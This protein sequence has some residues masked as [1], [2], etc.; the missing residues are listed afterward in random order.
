MAKLQAPSQG[1]VTKG[2]QASVPP[3]PRRKPRVG[4]F[5]F[6]AQ[7]RAEGDKVTWPTRKETLI[8]TVMVFVMAVLASLFF[9]VTDFVLQKAVGLV[10]GIGS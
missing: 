7:V 4:L 1:V 8:T 3:A 9:L 2:P 6:L 5:E 10:L